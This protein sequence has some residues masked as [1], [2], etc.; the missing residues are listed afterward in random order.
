MNV[1][2]IVTQENLSKDSFQV[3]K[4]KVDLKLS[5]AGSN[6]L[7]LSDDGLLYSATGGTSNNQRIPLAS[8]NGVGGKVYNFNNEFKADIRVQ[9]LGSDGKYLYIGFSS[10]NDIYVHPY[11]H[12]DDNIY[13][14]EYNAATI[15]SEYTEFPWQRP[16]QQFNVV[17]N[18]NGVTRTVIFSY[19]RLSGVF[20]IW[21]DIIC[22]E[23][24]EGFIED[25]GSDIPNGNFVIDGN[26]YVGVNVNETINQNWA[27][28]SAVKDADT[29][30]AD[31]YLVNIES[32]GTLNVDAPINA[33][34]FESNPN[35]IRYHWHAGSGCLT[36]LSQNGKY[37]EVLQGP[38]IAEFNTSFESEY[39][40]ITQYVSDESGFQ[41]IAVARTDQ[42]AVDFYRYADNKIEYTR[43][44]D[45]VLNNGNE[46]IQY[47]WDLAI[48]VTADNYLSTVYQLMD[49]DY[50]ITGKIIMRD[51]TT[52]N[53]VD[54]K[55]LFNYGTHNFFPDNSIFI[56]A[57]VIGGE[58]FVQLY[59]ITAGGFE[60]LTETQIFQGYGAM[61]SIY[62]RKL[63]LDP[64]REEEPEGYV[65][66]IIDGFVDNIKAIVTPYWDANSENY[67][68][69]VKH[70][71]SKYSTGELGRMSGNEAIYTKG[72]PWGDYA[73]LEFNLDLRTDA[74]GLTPVISSEV[75]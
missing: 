35:G 37:L 49:N 23:V 31:M 60:L 22:T 6:G 27:I 50:N 36:I 47:T 30:D 25:G 18:V 19:V 74:N 62:G 17:Y 57:V 48:N 15:V 54:E 34:Y 72:A 2:P 5:K 42:N 14:R 21:A 71:K 73:V 61:A 11:H 1:I 32:D 24:L 9:D 66:V 26:N 13:G 8:L 70:Y 29:G 68:L 46:G 40:N 16:A 7:K 53:I 58:V 56:D 65:G 39:T 59:E 43:T 67:V 69:D 38:Y 45:I 20:Y 64:N 75:S 4:G 52:G 41:C 55:S 28:L 12:Q 3:V 63:W 10:K 44:I 51:L 33:Y